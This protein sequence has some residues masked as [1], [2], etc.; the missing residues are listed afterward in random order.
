MAWDLMQNYFFVFL[1]FSF[2]SV[3]KYLVYTN[4]DDGIIYPQK[5]KRENLTALKKKIILKLSE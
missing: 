4:L 3:A 1:L 5:Y 2:S